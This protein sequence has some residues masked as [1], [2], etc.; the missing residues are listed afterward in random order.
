V[1]VWDKGQPLTHAGI[2]IR[3]A[4][5]NVGDVK[6]GG[7]GGVMTH[8][9]FRGRGFASAAVNRCIQFFREQGD[10]DFGLLV[11]EPHL[12]PFYERLGWRVFPGELVVEQH[13]VPTKFTL[14]GS[15]TYPLRLEAELAGTIDLL[16]PPW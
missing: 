16:G 4:R 7:V 1:F 9:E 14:C 6:V 11:C 12:V 5:W 3:Q 15:M 8:P 10:I 13:G 2:V